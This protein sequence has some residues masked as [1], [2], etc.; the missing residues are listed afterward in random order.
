MNYKHGLRH[1]SEYSTWVNMK[2]RCYNPNNEKYPVYGGRGIKVC[3]RWLKFQNF[4]DDMGPRPSENHSLDR[5]RNDRD[6]EPS[7]CRWATQKQQSLNKRRYKVEKTHCS[8][9]HELTPENQIEEFDK[10]SGYFNIRCKVCRNIR[11]AKRSNYV[12][13]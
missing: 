12:N 2:T 7:N 10:R 3:D 4:Y 11:N 5:I 1:S 8:Q 6:Y 13:T 9:G